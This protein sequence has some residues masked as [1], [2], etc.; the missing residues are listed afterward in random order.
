MLPHPNSCCF[1]LYILVSSVS[2]DLQW[3][4]FSWDTVP[5]FMH[6]CNFS[7]PFNETALQFFTKFPLITIEKGQGVY[8]TEEPYSS[9]YAEDNIVQACQAV[10]K[11]KP[12][13][14][15]IFYYNSINDWT[16]YFLHEIMASNPKYW[17]TAPNG[18][19]VLTGGDKSFPQ[20]EQGML[21]FDFQQNEVIDLFS[22]ECI[23]LTKNYPGIIDGC[24]V[25]KPHANPTHNIEYNF[26]KEEQ[27]A[28]EYGHNETLIRTQKYL[29]ESNN[30]ILISNNL[31]VP[32]GIIA[33]QMQGFQG[34]EEYI[35]DIMEWTQKGVLVEA[36]VNGLIDGNNNCTNITTS[37]AGFLI[38]AEKYSYYGCSTGWEVNDNWLIWHEEYDK[39][40]GEPLGKAV[41]NG[42]IYTREFKSGT[43]VVFNASS[44]VGQIFWADEIMH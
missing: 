17:L 23:N 37:L 32:N 20:P 15:C 26:S 16:M 36:R 35:L 3:P 19:V 38:A 41:K 44:S 25:D 29:N 34:I 33:T 30:S 10:K 4:E 14:T 1:F 7:G 22:N 42:D 6:M 11:L 21:V 5:V 28:F 9:N 24:F 13:I 39:P 40:L 31:F 18:T 43:K 27:Y 2:A 8:A 12:N